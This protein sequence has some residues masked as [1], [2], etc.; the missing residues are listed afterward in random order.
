MLRL[1]HGEGPRSGVNQRACFLGAG[2]LS[3][4]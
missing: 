3:L 2:S 4:T 1:T